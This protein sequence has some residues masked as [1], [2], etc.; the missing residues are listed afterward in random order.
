MRR[1]PLHEGRATSGV[2]SDTDAFPVA[3]ARM[4]DERVPDDVSPN[5]YGTAGS[6]G[7]RIYVDHSL[8]R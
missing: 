2:R 8:V 6:S 1:L 5:Q 7:I 4:S 3:K